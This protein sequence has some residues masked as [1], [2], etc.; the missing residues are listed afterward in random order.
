MGLLSR[1]FYNIIGY[2]YF[3][4]DTGVYLNVRSLKIPEISLIMPVELCYR[5]LPASQFPIKILYTFK[6]SIF[7]TP[8][9]S[10][11]KIDFLK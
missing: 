6:S 10:N 11:A 3:F 8:T 7:F 4:G 5:S 9:F 1:L 2:S